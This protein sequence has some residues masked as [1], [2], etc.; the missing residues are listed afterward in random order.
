MFGN[1]TMNHIATLT[2]SESLFFNR[3][4]ERS[5]LDNDGW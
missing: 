1:G 3:S 2:C 5:Y 4:V